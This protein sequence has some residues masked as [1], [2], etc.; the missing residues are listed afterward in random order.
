[1]YNVGFTFLSC[2]LELCSSLRLFKLEPKKFY[3]EK[4]NTGDV[5]QYYS[6]T[7]SAIIS[8]FVWFNFHG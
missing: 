5:R 8:G 3:E 6:T 1:V 2:C 4:L 7:D